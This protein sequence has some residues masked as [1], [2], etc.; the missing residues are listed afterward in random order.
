VI[1]S[2]GAGNWSD[3]G[4]TNADGRFPQSE[5]V[6]ADGMLYGTASEGGQQGYGTVFRLGTNG[7]GFSVLKHCA[8][9]VESYPNGLALDGAMLYGTSCGQIASNGGFGGGTIFRIQTNGSDFVLLK[10]FSG[11]YF[12]SGGYVNGEGAHPYAGVTVD[13]NVLYGTTRWGGPGGWGTVFRIG[14]DGTGFQMLTNFLVMSSDVLE[15]R[16]RPIVRGDRLYGTATWGRAG[17]VFSLSTNGTGLTNFG[18]S[19]YYGV[20]YSPL[21]LHGGV[22]YGVGEYQGGI[23]KCATN[24]ADAAIVKNFRLDSGYHSRSSLVCIDGVFYGTTYEGGISNNGAIFRCDPN[25]P[26]RVTLSRPQVVH[27][28]LAFEWNAIPGEWY[29]AQFT[30]NLASLEWTDDGEVIVAA[31]NSVATNFMV[32]NNPQRYYRVVYLP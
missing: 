1:W 26:H 21:L 20:S 29:Q 5:L 6:F 28:R 14:T 3:R 13:G 9:G 12:F 15:P 32:W 19:T 24:G 25:S 18:V 11:A 31:T 10:T 17:T 8:W 23:F 16:A 27:P 22:L 7:S 30:T 2:F 4:Y